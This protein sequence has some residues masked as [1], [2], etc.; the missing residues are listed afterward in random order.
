MI[1]TVGR[2]IGIELDGGVS[3]STIAE[4]ATAGANIFVAGSAVY[5]HR[6]YVSIISELKRLA[7]F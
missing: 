5:G 4:I 6:D 7:D 3:P 1:E 2:P